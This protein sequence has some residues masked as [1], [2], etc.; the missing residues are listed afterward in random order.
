MGVLR[1][2]TDRGSHILVVRGVALAVLDLGEKGDAGRDVQP[3]RYHMEDDF[4]EVAASLSVR[5][6]V[7]ANVVML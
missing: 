6:R 3:E 5:D 7:A 2:D 4:L 1:G